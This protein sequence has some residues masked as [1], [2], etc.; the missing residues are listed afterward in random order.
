MSEQLF[1]SEY[2]NGNR[3]AWVCRRRDL[4][5]YVVIGYINGL[6]RMG[7]PFATEH[8]ADDYAEDWVLLSTNE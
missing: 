3:T 2:V 8:E 1:L 6:E 7:H 5:D 4:K